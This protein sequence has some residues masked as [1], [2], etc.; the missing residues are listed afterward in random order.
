M[1]GRPGW[2][3][4]RRQLPT[5][6]LREAVDQVGCGRAGRCR[7]HSQAAVLLQRQPQLERW[8]SERISRAGSLVGTCVPIGVGLVRAPAVWSV[9]GVLPQGCHHHRRDRRSGRPRAP[10]RGLHRPVHLPRRTCCAS[11]AATGAS[12]WLRPASQ[13]RHDLFVRL[14]CPLAAGP[15]GSPP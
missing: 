11:R 9:A 3:E 1:R 6:G 8:I 4:D 13:M 2:A 5:G 10:A 14:R 12:C 7:L 15:G